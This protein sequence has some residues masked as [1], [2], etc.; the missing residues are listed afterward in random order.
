LED[1]ADQVR[2][3]GPI[4][5]VPVLV[6][7][8]GGWGNPLQVARSVRV[9]EQAGAAGAHIEDHEFGKHVTATPTVL[10]TAAAVDKIKAA[11]D[12]RRSEDFVVVA[13]TDCSTTLG[14]AA[15][16]ER[17]LAF[18]AAGADAVFVAGRLGEDDWLT[19]RTEAKVPVV[20]CNMP[21]TSVAELHRLGAA[22][23]LYYGMPQLSAQLALASAYSL[24]ARQPLDR[25][26]EADWETLAALRHFDELMGIGEV[27][28]KAA[29]YGL[30][31]GPD[32]STGSGLPS[33][34]P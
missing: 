18:E 29:E 16:V 27:R 13:R 3:L 5:G 31:G 21:G 25:P 14:G 34:A 26:V 6:D 15:A 7:A 10:T 17:L 20:S 30:L 28:R 8:E 24:L 19:L 4:A 2:R 23:I 33:G 11:L 1:V 32:L 22:V 12:A 9:L